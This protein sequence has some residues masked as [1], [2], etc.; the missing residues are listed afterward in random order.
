MVGVGSTGQ[1]P[2]R[3]E[4]LPSPPPAALGGTGIPVSSRSRAWLPLGPLQALRV[5]QRTPSLWPTAPG[6]GFPQS[7]QV[8][9]RTGRPLSLCLTL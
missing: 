8:W 7:N 2:G 6:S 3:E 1:E 9:A 5:Q 4:S